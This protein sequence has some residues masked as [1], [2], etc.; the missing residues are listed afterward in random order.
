VTTPLVRSA[1]LTCFADVCAERRLDPR[2][3]VAEMGLPG[4]CLDDPDLM[5]SAPAVGRLLELA[6]ARGDEPAFALRMAE[7]RRLS[8]LGPLALLL[9]DEPRLRD[10]LEAIV[11]HIHLQNE[12][13]TVRIEQVGSLVSIRMRLTGERGQPV[14]QGTELVVGVA[15]RVLATFL[16][17]SW[18]PR[19]VCFMHRAPRDLAVHRRVFGTAVEFGHEF[20]GIVCHAV[21]LDAPNPGA[22]PVMARYTSR[23]LG[24]RPRRQPRVSDRVREFIVLLLPRGRCRV[25]VVAQHL[26]VDRRTVA[27]H[28]AAEA[29]TFSTLVDDVRDELLARYLKESARPLAEVSPLLGFSDPTAFSRWHRTR[30]G[31]QART[32]LGPRTSRLLV[33]P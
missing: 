18:R 27:R 22:D 15:F 11:A 30:F 28:L 12:A 24:Q 10:A 6:A 9:R 20:D 8:N 26:G 16:G 21:D 19:V 5:V 4:R 14:R 17:A 25:E 33:R 7:S 29:T 3:L 13:L 1:S 2:Q 23:L 32:R 31:I